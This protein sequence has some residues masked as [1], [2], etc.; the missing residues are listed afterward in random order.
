[1]VTLKKK[2]T[3]TYNLFFTFQV[4]PRFCISVTY[5]QCV[6]DLGSDNRAQDPISFAT[7]ILQA[8]GEGVILVLFV[9]NLLIMFSN[10]V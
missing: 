4:L 2:I 9:D 8:F 6:S 7:G 5:F 1:M 3:S 10:S